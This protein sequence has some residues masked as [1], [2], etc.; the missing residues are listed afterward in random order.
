METDPESQ[1]EESSPWKPTL[2]ARMKEHSTGFSHG[3]R[4]GA[5]QDLG[6]LRFTGLD[7]LLAQPSSMSTSISKGYSQTPT[8]KLKSVT[9]SLSLV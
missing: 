5:G 9:C 3:G 2:K 1:D 8:S 7:F 4:L 6:Q